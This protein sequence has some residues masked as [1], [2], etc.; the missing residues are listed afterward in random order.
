MVHLPLLILGPPPPHCVP[1]TK[2]VHHHHNRPAACI[3]RDTI[4]K[5]PR[6]K[7]KNSRADDAVLVRECVLSLLALSHGR[8]FFLFFS[9]DATR[10][11]PLRCAPR[12]NDGCW[13]PPLLLLQLCSFKRRRRRYLVVVPKA[14]PEEYSLTWTI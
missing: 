13:P 9:F 10:S 7:E 5:N 4:K 6:K 2:G 3:G 14:A 1:Y 12:V 8:I 11:I